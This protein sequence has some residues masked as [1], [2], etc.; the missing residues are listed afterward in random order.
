MA[1]VEMTM[2]PEADP[3]SEADNTIASSPTLYIKNLN[4]KIK[5]EGIQEELCRL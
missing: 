5:L 2:A 3:T 1:E 4:E